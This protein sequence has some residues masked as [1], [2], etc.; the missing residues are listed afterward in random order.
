MATLRLILAV[1][2]IRLLICVLTKRFCVLIIFLDASYQCQT[3]SKH[4]TI[5]SRSSTRPANKEL[6]I[7]VSFHK[8]ALC[9]LQTAFYSA[10]VARHGF[11]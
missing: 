8:N 6:T 1:L 5:K 2:Y 11:H 3:M 7:S 10:F 9:I 4:T